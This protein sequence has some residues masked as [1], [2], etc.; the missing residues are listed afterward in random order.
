MKRYIPRLLIAAAVGGGLALLP[1]FVLP[2]LSWDGVNAPLRWYGDALRTLSLSGFAGNLAAWA[3]VLVVSLLPLLLL[4]KGRGWEKGLL[5][6]A[7][8][9]L[10]MGQYF[11]VNPS[12]LNTPLREAFPMAALETALSLVAAWW[13]L[14]WLRGLR[15]GEQSRLV[16]TFRKLFGFCAFLLVGASGF[17]TVLALEEN[18][19]RIEQG[20]TAAP[21]G[22]G[23]TFTV[24]VLLSVLRFLPDLLAGL[25]LLLGGELAAELDNGF[26]QISVELC[27]KVAS[28]CA[29]AARI[30]VVTAAGLNLLQLLLL[31]FLRDSSF[32]LEIP[33]FTLA[34]S[35]GLML[36]CRLL[37]R[38]RA[39]Q[40]DSDSI[41]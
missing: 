41:I 18:W 7:V 17:G 8:P 31:Q 11:A 30:T 6:A 34:L 1:G 36:L 35:A 27:E 10:L 40:E 26:G 23:L 32:N 22:L 16:G 9:V 39:L 24:L 12:Y 20:N 29:M 3:I 28:A 37:E 15:E 14:D 38:G 19:A 33:L 25:T 13:A 2:A 5:I 21:D 4:R